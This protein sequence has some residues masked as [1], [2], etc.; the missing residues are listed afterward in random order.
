MVGKKHVLCAGVDLNP[1]LG[2]Q[3]NDAAAMANELKQ[4]CISGGGSVLIPKSIK[5]EFG[6]IS[7]ILNI[8]W[9]ERGIEKEARLICPRSSTCPR[10]PKCHL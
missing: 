3:G 10:N 7:R 1:A 6:R 5:Q 2:A 8:A 4:A 9:L